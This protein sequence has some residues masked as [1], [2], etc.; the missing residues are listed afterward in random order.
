MPNLDRYHIIYPIT[1]SY[2]FYHAEWHGYTL[3]SSKINLSLFFFS[4]YFLVPLIGCLL[5]LICSEVWFW[6][7]YIIWFLNIHGS[8]RF[9]H[10][11]RIHSIFVW[12]V[13]I[14]ILVFGDCMKYVAMILAVVLDFFVTLF[15]S[16]CWYYSLHIQ[17]ISRFIFVVCHSS[18][19]C[20]ASF[21]F[22]RSLYNPLF[23]I[24]FSVNCW[25]NHCI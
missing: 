16:W 13:D 2:L 11:I 1:W 15:R 22:N 14:W 4:G 19:F 23:G 25:I 3:V 18:L 21:C 7:S 24:F 10:L 6:Y 8:F 5:F 12:Y 20:L 9:V 17:I